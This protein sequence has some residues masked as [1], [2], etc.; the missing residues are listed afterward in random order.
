MYVQCLSWVNRVKRGSSPR[1]ATEVFLLLPWPLQ[2]QPPCRPKGECCPR[3]ASEGNDAKEADVLRC[4]SREKTRV[5]IAGRAEVR[6][7]GLVICGAQR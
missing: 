2:T 5:S 7:L 3:R 1:A 4:R 6:R